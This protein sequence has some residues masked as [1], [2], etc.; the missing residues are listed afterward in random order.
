MT[1][2]P[3]GPVLGL[4][5]SRLPWALFAVTCIVYLLTASYGGASGDVVTSNLA[6]WQL[7][8]GTR[9]YLDQFT[10]PPLEEHPGRSIWVI[11]DAAGR[12]IVGR[13]AGP[14]LMGVPA[15]ALAGWF[16]GPTFSLVPGAAT[17]AVATALAVALFASAVLPWLG[18]K[19][20]VLA[21]LALAFA[22]PMWTVAANALW[23]QTVSVLGICGM[24]RAASRQRWWLAGAFGGLALSG[25]FQVAILVAVLCVGL[26][27]ARRSPGVALR[28][29]LPSGLAFLALLPWNRWMYD[30]WSPAAYYNPDDIA[31]YAPRGPLDPVNQLG[32][33]ISLD[34]GILVWTP[35]ILVLLLVLARQWRRVPDWSLA[36]AAAGVTYTVVETSFI[37]FPGGDSFYG[38]RMTL[39]LLVC[40]APA[41]SLAAL[42]AGRLTTSMLAPL[43]TLQLVAMTIGAVNEGLGLEASQAWR[44]NSFVDAVF[45][46]PAVGVGTILVS[47]LIGLVGRRIWDDPGLRR[48]PDPGGSGATS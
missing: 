10:Y 16:V 7:A 44:R 37:A 23:P 42:H 8:S 14:V 26:A 45:D 32:P 6:S 29:A 25:R 19:N 20:T 39:E 18:G 1:R 36:L 17:A 33:W 28:M 11:V 31:K 12:E 38:Y 46:R 43:L 2:D 9:P 21:A 13:A 35:V 40:L 41:V 5:A 27:L 48:G 34:R 3:R 4:T 47:L 30:S 15:Y 22:T 24:A